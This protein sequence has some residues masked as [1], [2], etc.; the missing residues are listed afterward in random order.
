MTSIPATHYRTVDVTRLKGVV[1]VLDDRWFWC[2]NGDPKQAIFYTGSDKRR[3]PGSPQCNGS[4]A[5]SERVVPPLDGAEL[6][7]VKQAFVPWED[8]E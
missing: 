5:I 8:R 3:Y 1:Q 7:F 2:V 4:K 6:V